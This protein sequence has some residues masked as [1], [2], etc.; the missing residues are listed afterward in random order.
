M[1]ADKIA[2]VI[3][4]LQESLTALSSRALNPPTPNSVPQLPTGE[5]ERLQGIITALKEELGLKY[6]RSRQAKSLVLI[7][8]L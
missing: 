4:G 5:I 7:D 8:C 1:A 2:S 3:E 6:F